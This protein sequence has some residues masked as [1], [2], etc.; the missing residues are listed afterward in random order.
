MGLIP[1]ILDFEVEYLTLL[2]YSPR[3]TNSVEITSRQ[4]KD[5]IKN[6]SFKHV[7]RALDEIIKQNKLVNTFLNDATLVPVPGSSLVQ[8]G[9]LRVPLEICLELAKVKNNLEV[10]DCLER[11]SP[12]AKA[13]AGFKAEDRPSHQD[14]VKSI[15]LKDK[16]IYKDTIIL[17][18][19][20]LTTGMTA[21]SCAKILKGQYPD[22]EI[23]IFALLRPTRPTD[24]I[25]ED[26]KT[27]RHIEHGIAILYPSEKTY[28]KPL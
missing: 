5:S 27:F 26:V 11:Y 23:K 19:D 17:V 6:W 2:R 20:V 1:A 3:G 8:A 22:K 10:V 9:A 18:D 12:V 15:K 7:N 14:H 16:L 4:L 25:P 28:C 13:K 21:L 24:T